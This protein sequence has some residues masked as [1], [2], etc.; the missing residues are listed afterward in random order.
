M[1]PV[2]PASAFEQSALLAGRSGV[3]EGEADRFLYLLKIRLVQY[4]SGHPHEG[5][6]LV[7]LACP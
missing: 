7:R 5:R 6:T 2:P 1:R 3:D 4:L